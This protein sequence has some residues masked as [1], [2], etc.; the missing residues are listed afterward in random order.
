MTLQKTCERYFYM[1]ERGTPGR[2]LGGGRRS[3]IM[4]AF[5]MVRS[6]CSV[7]SCLSTADL[8]QLSQL[9][10]NGVQIALRK[11][12]CPGQPIGIVILA[13]C[14]FWVPASPPRIS[15]YLSNHKMRSQWDVLCYGNHVF[16][17]MRIPTGRHSVNHISV[18]QALNPTENV[19]FQETMMEPS[20][21]LIVYA[22]IHA[23]IVSE[24]AMGMDSTTIP[25]LASGFAVNTD[26]PG[27][28]AA[29][30]T[31][32]GIPWSGGSFLTVGFQFLAC[33]SLSTEDVSVNVIPT[34]HSF[35]NRTARLIKAAFDC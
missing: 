32:S 23:S 8:Q 24:L 20:G 11:S 9:S 14:T 21:A 6:Y 35:V 19:I 30:A 16:E 29:L 27:Q 7:F 34:V 28:R 3:M 25:I 33:S 13:A 17:I 2:E 12:S 1:S 31:T 10:R 26:G 15:E 22:P 4:L 18:L 5:R